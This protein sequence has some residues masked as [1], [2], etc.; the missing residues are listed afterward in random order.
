ME[1]CDFCNS[2]LLLIAVLCAC[3][4]QLLFLVI[5]CLNDEEP[6]VRKVTYFSSVE[7]CFDTVGWAT[8]RTSGL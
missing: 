7:L 2:S 5:R 4:Q 1:I 3:R 6:D 8:G